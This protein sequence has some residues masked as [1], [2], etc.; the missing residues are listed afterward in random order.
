V[1]FSRDLS[2]L[3]SGSYDKTVKIWDLGSGECLKTLEGH[4]GPITSV[5][6][7]HDSTQV[8]SGSDDQTVKIWDANSGDCLQTL[9]GHS[10][11]VRSVTFLQDS[12]QLASTS[13]D[14]TV[15]IWDV[16]SG[17]CLLTLDAGTALCDISWDIVGSC[18]RTD[19]GDIFIGAPPITKNATAATKPCDF[20]QRHTE[21]SVD[22]AWITLNHKRLVWLP[23]GYR[24]S[25]W[26]VSGQTIGMGVSSGKVWMCKVDVEHDEVQQPQKRILP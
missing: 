9:E 16:R 26:I 19:L 14:K 11:E 2:R 5:A 15:K 1:T 4:I 17:E 6:F 21:P 24:P 18:L 22:G 25:Y 10:D 3:A 13:K 8:T 12:T 7:S 20:Q 23:P